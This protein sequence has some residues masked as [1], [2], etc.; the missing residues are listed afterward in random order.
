MMAEFRDVLLIL[1]SQIIGIVKAYTTRVGA[2]I[3]PTEDTA[4]V[5]VSNN[6]IQKHSHT[7]SL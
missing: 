2:G 7:N 1:R 5:G 4:E 3:F 6:C